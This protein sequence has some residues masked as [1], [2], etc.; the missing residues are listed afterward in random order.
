MKIVKKGA[1]LSFTSNEASSKRT[2][3][4]S[5]RQV[6]LSGTIASKEVQDI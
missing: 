4:T 5:E 6:Y 1:F 2:G 3:K